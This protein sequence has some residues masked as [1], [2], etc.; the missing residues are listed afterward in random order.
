MRQNENLPITTNK[1]HQ[2]IKMGFFNSEQRI[3]LING[4]L[5]QKPQVSPQHRATTHRLRKIL[6]DV[7]NSESRNSS[8]VF[9]NSPITLAQLNSEPEP[10]LVVVTARDDEYRYHH[11]TASDIQVLIEVSDETL[12]FDQMEKYQLY[13]RAM[14][15]DYWFI[16][17]V[18]DEIEFYLSPSISDEGQ[19]C[20]RSKTILPLDDATVAQRIYQQQ[21]IERTAGAWQG[22]P[23]TRPEQGKFENRLEFL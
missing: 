11:P 17:L 1:Y 16:N 12:V 2:L 7:I 10:D 19:P 22:E 5:V 8:I 23:L 14:I 18:D 20:Y 4:L 15:P 6:S 9:M 21:F 3:E 13:A